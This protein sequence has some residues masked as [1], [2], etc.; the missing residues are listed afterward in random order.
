MLIGYARVST[1]DQSLDL[2]IDFLKSVGC[3]DI[4]QEKMTGKTKERPALKDISNKNGRAYG[5]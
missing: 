1:E 2:Q 4:Y 3:H 5:A